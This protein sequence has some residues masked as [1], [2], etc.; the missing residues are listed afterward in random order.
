M[1][2]ESQILEIYKKYCD[3][4]EN[5]T[6]RTFATNKFYL[7][8]EIVLLVILAVLVTLEVNT[9]FIIIFSALGILISLLWWLNHDAYLYLIKIKYRDV[10]EK[11]EEQLPIAPATMEFKVS[12]EERARKKTFVFSDVHKAISFTILVVFFGMFL[13]YLVP[14]VT[15]IVVT[16]MAQ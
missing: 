10:I 16:G 2:K 8:L 14:F 15:L 5:F 1:D 12:K 11:I 4:K 13:Y 3:M 7:L 9:L 6:D